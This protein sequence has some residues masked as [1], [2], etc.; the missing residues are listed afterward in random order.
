MSFLRRHAWTLGLLALFV[1]LL[2]VTRLIQPNFGVSGLESLARASLP[3]AFATAAM[4]VVV[5]AG[6]IDLSV[7]SMMA[8]CSVTAAV[9]MQSMGGVPAI[10]LTLAWVCSWGSST[11]R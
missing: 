8:V 11:G 9:L 4:A 3:F 1:L 10:L 2:L 6:G 7:G 5:I